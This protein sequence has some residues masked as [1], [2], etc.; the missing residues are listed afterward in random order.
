[1]QIF[2]MIDVLMHQ[3]MIALKYKHLRLIQ[4]Q[5]RLKN[6]C[7]TYNAMNNIN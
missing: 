3:Y 1:M 2:E 5:T 7:I 6:H 4:V